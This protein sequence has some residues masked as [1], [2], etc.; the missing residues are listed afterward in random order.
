MYNQLLGMYQITGNPLFLK[1]IQQ[2]FDLA[3]STADASDEEMEKAGSAAWAGTFLRGEDNPEANH[4][5]DGIKMFG[6]AKTITGWNKYDEFLAQY[7]DAYTKY[8]ISGDMGIVEKEL[9]AALSSLRANFPLYTSEVKFTD[10][11]YV[12]GEEM[13]FGMYTGYSGRGIESPAPAVTWENTGTGVGVLVNKAQTDS[14]DISLYNFGGEK[15]I[16]MNCWKLEPG[17]YK[18]IIKNNE[19]FT[20]RDYDLIVEERGQQATLGLPQKGEYQVI[21][22]QINKSN[23]SIFPAPDLAIGVGD[24]GLT[25]KSISGT[26]SIDINVIV[27]N[28]GNAP[29]RN[30]EVKAWVDGKPVGSATID[31]IDAPNDLNAKTH[32]V[33]MSW[34]HE[35]GPHDFLIVISCDQKEITLRNNE[36]SLHMEEIVLTWK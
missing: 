5:Q 7:G 12:D 19:G 14:M 20:V 15:E 21:V 29:A 22:S 25:P 6:L 17:N 8:Q 1:P 28:I 9:E 31:Q 26:D 18:I 10:R 16:L 36:F 34:R 24:I 33:R 27:H 13:L 35:T 11:V 2:T 23:T 32:R 30:I 4:L 3:I